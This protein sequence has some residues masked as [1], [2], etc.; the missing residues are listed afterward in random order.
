MTNCILTNVNSKAMDDVD[1]D[2]TRFLQIGEKSKKEISS[3]RLH[4]YS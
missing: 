2:I 4:L 3:L 1:L